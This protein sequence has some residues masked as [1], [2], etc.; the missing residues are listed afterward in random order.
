MDLEAI[1]ARIGTQLQTISGL[2]VDA[3]GRG[4]SPTPPAAIV[5][6]PPGPFQS[7]VTMD[8]A[9]DLDLVVLALV[10]KADVLTAQANLD[11]LLVQVFA[12]VQA[13]KTADWD[14]VVATVARGYGT[15]T[16]GDGE[17]AISFLGAEI[18]LQVGC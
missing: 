13:D 3:H 15:Y 12:A 6:V 7:V 11:A 17:G 10:R 14:Y 1:R 18:P 5:M 4:Q 2:Y 16:W 9:T 8:D